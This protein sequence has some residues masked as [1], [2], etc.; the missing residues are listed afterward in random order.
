MMYVCITDE[1][2]TVL[3]HKNLRTNPQEF[4]RVIEPYTEDLAVSEAD[5]I[6]P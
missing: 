1:S 6:R 3:L 5:E 2:G 4:T